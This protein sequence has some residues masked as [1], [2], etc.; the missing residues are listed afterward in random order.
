MRPATVSDDWLDYAKLLPTGQSRRANHDC[1]HGGKLSL[2]YGNNSKGWWV[3]CY[4]CGFKDFRSKEH[5]VYAPPISAQV[6]TPTDLV[7]ITQLITERPYLMRKAL[8][9]HGLLPHLTVLTA[10]P[11]YGRIY[12]P[13][14]SE[15][16]C[17][18]DYTGTAYAWWHSPTGSTL[19][20]WDNPGPLQIFAEAGPYLEAVRAGECAMFVP[21]V[22]EKSL[23]SAA[24]LVLK[25]QFPHVIIRNHP[26]AARIR[27]ELAVAGV[28]IDIEN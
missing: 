19:A 21:V 23:V 17:G 26:S 20:L 2:V 18:L 28:P 14:T 11:A 16:Y 10:S 12:L 7:P 3:R 4:R 24:A 13:D 22:S 15:S 9:Q 27:K 6:K 8:E 1:R 25:H 5:V